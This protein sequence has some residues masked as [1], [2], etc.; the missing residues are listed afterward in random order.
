MDL[1][2]DPLQF[3]VFE[4][5]RQDGRQQARRIVELVIEGL[6]PRP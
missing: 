6:R 2:L 3:G 1:G 5:A 4:E